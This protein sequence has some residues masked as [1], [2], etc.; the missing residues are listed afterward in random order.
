M[1]ES[2]H[3]HKL[4]AWFYQLPV[5]DMGGGLTIVSLPRRWMDATDVDL[6]KK[7]LA[8]LADVSN[9]TEG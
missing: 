1:T 9:G 6:I 8:R 2:E 7:A 3:C 5:Y 4:I